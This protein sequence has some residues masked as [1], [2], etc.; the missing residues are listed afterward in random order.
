MSV[1]LLENIAIIFS[2]CE[3]TSDVSAATTG[4]LLLPT[5]H[6]KDPCQDVPAL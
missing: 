1:F 4:I 6:G 5:T 3:L 2:S